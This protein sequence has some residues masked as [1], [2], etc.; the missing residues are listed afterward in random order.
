VLG[1]LPRERVVRTQSGG[2][3]VYLAH[4]Y[5]GIR[6]PTGAGARSPLGRL[7]CGAPGVDVR[8]NGGIVVLPP[9]LGYRWIADD[10]GPFPPIPPLWLAA[11]PGRG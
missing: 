6:V 4:P 2:L 3:H 7:P 9:S 8:A 1:P 11:N 5:D 10:D